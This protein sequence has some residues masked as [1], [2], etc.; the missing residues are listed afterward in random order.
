MTATAGGLPAADADLRG[1][2]GFGWRGDAL[3]ADE[4]SLDALAR[5]HG[6]PLYV[7]A[8]R[9]IRTALGRLTA[10]FGSAPHVVAYS[11]KAN[12][13]L[14]VVSPPGPRGGRGGR[15]LPRRARPRAQG[16]RA[17]VEGRLLRDGQARGRASRR[18]STPASSSSTSRSTTS[19]TTSRG[20]R[21][22]RVTASVGLRVNPDT[23]AGDAPL[24]RHREEGQ[25]VRR[26]LGAGPRGPAPRGEPAE[27]P[28]AGAQLPHREPAHEPGPRGRGARPHA[29][30]VPRAPR[31]RAPARPP[32]RRG[33]ARGHV[34][35]RGPA[36][37]GGLRAD[38]AGRDGRP[39]G[40]ARRRAGPAR[41]WPAPACS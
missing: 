8:A 38:R 13:C 19:S 32:R 35:R 25:Q 14:A 27:P 33:R 2:D 31:R 12:P 41:S 9:P 21:A 24:H 29:R 36:R 22:R 4:V 16:R 37:G 3:H 1:A 20:S 23:D 28:R 6:T 30:P 7:Y 15:R 17:G 11:V 26:A 18:G 39:R 34:H 5:T 10:A 40:H